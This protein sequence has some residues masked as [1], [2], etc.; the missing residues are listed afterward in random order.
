ML[1]IMIY[2]MANWTSSFFQFFIGYSMSL[3]AIRIN[4][5]E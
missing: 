5:A 4:T 1:M 2:L 3:E